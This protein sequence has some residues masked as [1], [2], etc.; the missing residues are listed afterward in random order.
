MDIHD[1][2]NILLEQLDDIQKL[3]FVG[4]RH[5]WNYQLI[6]TKPRIWSVSNETN[7][8]EPMLTYC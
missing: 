7:G 2:Q 6:E 5:L 8:S 3:S 1:F 4:T